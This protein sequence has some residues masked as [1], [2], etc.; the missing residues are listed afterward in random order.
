MHHVI[1]LKSGILISIKKKE[2]TGHQ[3]NEQV[4]LFALDKNSSLLRPTQEAMQGLKKGV[5][6]T[7]VSTCTF[8]PT[9]FTF[10]FRAT[11]QNYFQM[12]MW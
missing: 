1:G 7:S 4:H 11:C 5:A 10:D 8:C 6:V 9:L 2:K 12:I 3:I